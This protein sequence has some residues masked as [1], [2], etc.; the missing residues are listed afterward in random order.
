MPPSC[1]GA[2][3]SSTSSMTAVSRRTGSRP[4][5]ASRETTSCTTEARQRCLCENPR[6]R[7]PGVPVQFFVIQV[8]ASVAVCGFLAA[9]WALT[10]GSFGELSELARDPTLSRKLGFWPIWVFL[11]AAAALVVHLGFVVAKLFGDRARPRR[12]N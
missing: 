8:F 12:Q 1:F 5:H 2:S 7:Q 9:A 6:H 11:A 10:G 4:K 3:R